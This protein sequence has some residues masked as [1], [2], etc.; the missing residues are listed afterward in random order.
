MECKRCHKPADGFVPSR[1]NWAGC[2]WSCRWVCID[3]DSAI[4]TKTPSRRLRCDACLLLH[5]R[6]IV[7]LCNR[8]RRAEERK[9]NRQDVNV[10][11]A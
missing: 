5:R 6:K 8:R 4:T 9:R 11:I 10:V 7:K 3:C 2:C 1:G